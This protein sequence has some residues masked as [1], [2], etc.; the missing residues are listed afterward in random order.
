MPKT[1]STRKREQITLGESEK[2]HTVVEHGLGRKRLSLAD[3]EEDT[4]ASQEP[5]ATKETDE[6]EDGSRDE[7]ELEEGGSTVV[8]A[9][10][11]ND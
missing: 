3:A 1:H 10:L 9:A 4:T 11:T 8:G 6:S 5:Q 7:E 2:S